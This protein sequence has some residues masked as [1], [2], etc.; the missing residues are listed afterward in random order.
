[1]DI[2]TS[3]RINEDLFLNILKGTLRQWLPIQYS[4]LLSQ[5]FWTDC[6]YTHEDHVRGEMWVL[7]ET[8]EAGLGINHGS[9]LLPFNTLIV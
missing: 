4:K 7:R 2:D 8:L 3:D 9:M 5:N 1:M 6:K